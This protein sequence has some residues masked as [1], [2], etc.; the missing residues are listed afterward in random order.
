MEPT[1]QTDG[2]VSNIKP[3]STIRDNKQGT[4]MS[5]DGAISADRRVIKKELRIF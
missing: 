1:V 3:D 2:I 5:I 4:C